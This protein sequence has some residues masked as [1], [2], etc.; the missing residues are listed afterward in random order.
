MRDVL[1]IVKFVGQK[2]ISPILP[3]TDNHPR[4][5]QSPKSGGSALMVVG[6]KKSQS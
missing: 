4:I 3:V 5:F 6:L 2:G 1:K